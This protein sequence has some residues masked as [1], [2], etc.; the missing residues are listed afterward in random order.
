M[1]EKR[2]VVR[3][4][5]NTDKIYLLIDNEKSIMY[6]FFEDHK[7]LAYSLCD[8]LNSLSEENEQ[9]KKELNSFQPV[10]FQDVRKGTVTLYSK[11]MRWKNGDKN[12]K[13]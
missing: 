9:L 13:D 1:S 12:G 10:M 6:S 5:A 8:L 11:E 2:F 7:Q 3:V 4:D